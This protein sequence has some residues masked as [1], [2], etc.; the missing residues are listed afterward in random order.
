MRLRPIQLISLCVMVI[1][2]GLLS[3]W[4][5]LEPSHQRAWRADHSRL[6]LVTVT[7]ATTYKI[8][9]VRNWT[10][11][12][13]EFATTTE[14]LAAEL[15]PAELVQVWL[16]MEPFGN[17]PAIAHTMLSFEFQDGSAYVVSME[18]RR[19][20]GE[21]YRPLRAALIPTYEYMFVWST[22]RDMLGN[23]QYFT[24]DELFLYPLSLTDE[25][26]QLLLETFLKETIS[27]QQQPR[28]YHTV[29]AN[30]TN[31][32][33]RAINT[34]WPG[35][36]PLD[37]SWFLPGYADSFLHREGWLAVDADFVT[38]ERAAHISPY[39]DELYSLTDP[40]AFSVALRGRLLE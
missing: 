25:E 39:I 29:F 18:A 28:W 20:E 19:E 10:Y 34:R 37:L 16:I 33:V 6:P 1:G 17:N 5:I 12:T 3:M 11:G 23:S 36:I 14:W 40:V 30:C 8:E 38:A 9:N 32:L 31:V 4:F 27:L 7:E 26:G 21:I 13:D 2:V 35:T 15:L 24:G 22:E